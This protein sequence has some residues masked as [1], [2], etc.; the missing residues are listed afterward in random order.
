VLLDQ[1]RGSNCLDQLFGAWINCNEV[2]PLMTHAFPIADANR[3]F[4]VAV[5]RGSSMKVHLHFA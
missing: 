4:E 2:L 3:A 5:D 1:S